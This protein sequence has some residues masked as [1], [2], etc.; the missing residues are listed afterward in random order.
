M[1]KLQ[2]PFTLTN[3]NANND[4]IKVNLDNVVTSSTN[5]MNGETVWTV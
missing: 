1:A 4:T 3:T 2:F 5:A